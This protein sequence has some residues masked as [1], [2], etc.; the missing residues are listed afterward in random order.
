MVA[1]GV[2]D[3]CSAHLGTRHCEGAQQTFPPPGPL[4]KAGLALVV[5]V[6]D[7][8]M[9]S[10]KNPAGNV[11]EQDR[12]DFWR[13]HGGGGGIKRKRADLGSAFIRVEVGC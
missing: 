11:E 2:R 1:L 4:F 12:Y 9:Y 10:S 7:F 6:I 3:A 8:R 5:L 13:G